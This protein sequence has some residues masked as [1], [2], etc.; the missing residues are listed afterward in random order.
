MRARTTRGG[1][2]R[3]VWFNE[4]AADP[5]PDPV[6]EKVRI[7]EGPFGSRVWIFPRIPEGR[8]HRSAPP[9]AI[10]SVAPRLYPPDHQ[11]AITKPFVWVQIPLPAGTTGVANAIQ[12]IAVNCSTASNVEIW[13][14]Q[15]R[16]TARA[17]SSRSGRKGTQRGTS[18]A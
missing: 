6:S 9:P 13:N 11:A 14:E 16:S 7:G 4:T 3:L 10:S 15:S 1:V 12:R 17:R 8:R 18:W 5:R 2:Q